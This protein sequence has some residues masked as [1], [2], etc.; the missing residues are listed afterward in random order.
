ML[1]C[2]LCGG[3]ITVD[4]D[5]Q[6]EVLVAVPYHVLGDPIPTRLQRATVASCDGCEFAATVD[7]RGAVRPLCS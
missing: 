4:R 5:A 6:L 2:P 3:S 1:T 7:A